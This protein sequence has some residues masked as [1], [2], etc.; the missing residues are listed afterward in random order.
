MSLNPNQFDQSVVKGQLDLK[1]Q[2]SVISCQVKSDESTPLVPGQAVLMVDSAGGVPKVTAATTDEEDIFG[3]VVRNNKQS[4]F[5]AG[6]AVEIAMGRGCV[7]YMEAGAAVARNA[8]VQVVITG[9]KVITAAVGDHRIVG[10]ALDKAAA[11]ADLIRVWIDLPG[12][13]T[14]S[15]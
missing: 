7:M 5:A 8:Q 4:S 15:S 3:F 14:A 11:D 9:Q 2:P 10:R 12:A 6:E 1:M 13:Q